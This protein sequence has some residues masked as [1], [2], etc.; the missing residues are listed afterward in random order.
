MISNNLQNARL[1]GF[2]QVRVGSQTY[3]V[4]VQSVRFERDQ[5]SGAPAGGFFVD[6]GG[7]DG[8]GILV[9]GDAS[10]GDIEAQIKRASE[11]AVRHI[12]KQFLN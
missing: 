1:L 3:A 6:E 11:D 7:A 9:D 5:S 2:V 12:S 4:P 10:E 8:Y